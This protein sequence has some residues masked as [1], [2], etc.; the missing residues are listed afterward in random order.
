M[1]ADAIVVRD[2]TKAFGTTAG[3]NSATMTS[4]SGPSCLSAEDNVKPM[5]RPPISIQAPSR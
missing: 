1:A 5:P 3:T 4:V 2:V